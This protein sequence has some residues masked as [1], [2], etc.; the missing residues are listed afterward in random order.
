M[1]KKDRPVPDLAVGGQVQLTSG[2]HK[3]RIGE[4]KSIDGESV[5]LRVLDNA[6]GFPLT[7]KKSEFVVLRGPDDTE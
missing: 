6:D 4:V 5:E 7:V 1:A 2:Q 3:N